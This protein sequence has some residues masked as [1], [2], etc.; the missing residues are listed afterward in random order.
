MGRNDDAANN[1]NNNGGVTGGPDNGSNNAGGNA[2]NQPSQSMPAWGIAVIVILLVVILGLV[3][4]V[5][6]KKYVRKQANS[7]LPAQGR[8][9][10]YSVQSDIGE[11]FSDDD[12]D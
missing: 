11:E 1:N 2:Q 8:H 7:V 6:W 10:K 12:D 5:L 9:M 3:G 4:F